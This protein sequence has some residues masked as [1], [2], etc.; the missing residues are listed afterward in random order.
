MHTFFVQLTDDLASVL[1][2]KRGLSYRV[3]VEL[4]GRPPE[5]AT[6]TVVQRIIK[7]AEEEASHV[8]H[9]DMLVFRCLDI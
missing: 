5:H 7:V 8:I 1:W 2:N 6:E 4:T 9:F 3:R